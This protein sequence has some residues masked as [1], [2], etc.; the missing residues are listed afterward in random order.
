VRIPDTAAYDA[1][2]FTAVREQL[3]LV[4]ESRKEPMD[5]LVIEHIEMPTAN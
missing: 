3:G 1:G 5:A 2:I 4:L